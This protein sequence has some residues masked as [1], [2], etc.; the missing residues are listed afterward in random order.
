MAIT[1]HVIDQDGNT[2]NLATAPGTSLM[3]VIREAG[4]PI[5]A[6]CGGS[7][8]C[9][10]CQVYVDTD[11]FVR[12]PEAEYE[13]RIVLE[14]EAYI[15]RDTSRLSCQIQVTADLDGIK[16]TLPPTD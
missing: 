12:L 11:W 15:L 14:E 10:T 5:P 9:S 13:E 4:L 16:V 3:E 6:I 1:V 7:C 8:I 2:H